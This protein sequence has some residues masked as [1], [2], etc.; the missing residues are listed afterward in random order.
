[1]SHWCKAVIEEVSSPPTLSISTGGTDSTVA[2]YLVPRPTQG[3]TATKPSDVLPHQMSAQSNLPP[4]MIQYY[5]QLYS[6]A[7]PSNNST[8]VASST[9]GSIQSAAPAI[10]STYT[11]NYADGVAGTVTSSSSGKAKP[12]NSRFSPVASATE[13]PTFFNI[14]SQST[15]SGP[16]IGVAQNTD[17]ASKKGNTKGQNTGTGGQPQS[18]K[19]FVLR[20]FAQCVTDDERTHVRSELESLISRVAAEGRTMVH[21]W[22]LEPCPDLPSSSVDTKPTISVGGYLSMQSKKEEDSTP[23]SISGRK[24]KSRFSSDSENVNMPGNNSKLSTPRAVDNEQA[25]SASKKKIQQPAL[26]GLDKLQTVEEMKMREQ[27]ANRFAV[28][29]DSGGSLQDKTFNSFPSGNSKAPNNN[30]KGLLQAGKSGGKKKAAAA[31]SATNLSDT[32]AD[33][34]ME[35]LK[36]VGTCEKLEKDYLRLTSAPHPSVVRPERVL[37]KSIQLLKKKWTEESVEYIYM[38]SQLKSIR[39]DLTVQHIQNDFTVHV[40]ETHARVALECGDMNEYNQCQ[41][42]L[43][44]LYAAGL[45][46]NEMEFVAYRILYYVYLLGNKKYTSGS[47]DLAFAMA[48]LTEEHYRDAAV[49]HALEVRKAVQ[50]DNYHKFFILYKCPPNMGIYIMDL[51]VDNLRLQAL[52]RICKGYKP[53]VEVSFVTGALAFDGEDVC[54][55]FLKKAGC[56]VTGDSKEYQLNTKDSVIDSSAIITKEKLLL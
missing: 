10:Q 44:Q 26:S 51:L 19:E 32:G 42:Q 39:Q 7:K 18:M 8:T 6:N 12:K 53:Q 11:A 40:Y 52:Q 29:E 41:T 14:L 54:L 27:R 46:G 38:C 23:T 5:Q 2:S 49:A 30:A 56:V 16:A 15:T 1:M 24:R 3:G 33:F 50:L 31:V 28:S 55:E 17:N 37:R 45:K 13:Q 20:C 36:I 25:A 22:D 43:K 48:S 4:N 34:D 35:S 9:P 21:R 47:S